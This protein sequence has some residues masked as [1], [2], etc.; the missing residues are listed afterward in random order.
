MTAPG[1]T[2]KS[3][4]LYNIFLLLTPMGKKISL[5]VSPKGRNIAFYFCKKGDDVIREPGTTFDVL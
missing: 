3:P 5:T 2:F 4:P 1:I